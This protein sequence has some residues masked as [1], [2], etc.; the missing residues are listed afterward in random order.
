MKLSRNTWHY[1]LFD[2]MNPSDPDPKD[3]CS[4]FWQLMWGLTWRTFLFSWIA[5]LICIVLYGM[6]M[7]IIDPTHNIV[8]AGIFG[9]AILGVSIVVFIYQKISDKIEERRFGLERK[10]NIFIEKYKAWKTKSCPRI[11]WKD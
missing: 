4:Y 10:P 7:L 8:P 6:V 11:D 5:F 3:F 2:K 9:Y 1:W